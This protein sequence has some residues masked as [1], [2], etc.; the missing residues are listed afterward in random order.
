MP[1]ILKGAERVLITCVSD[2]VMAVVSP[3][4]ELK[5]DRVHI[6][7]YVR[8][9]TEGKKD[10]QAREKYYR[11]FIDEVKKQFENLHIPIEYHG[12]A[13]TYVFNE[14]MAEVYGTI[15]KET[16]LGS[17]IYVNISG[18]TSEYAA[19]AYVSAMMGKGIELF[20]T[21]M[22]PN[23]SPD[24][25]DKLIAAKTVDGQLVGSSKE[26]YQMFTLTGFNIEPPDI[27]LLMA[28]KVFSKLSKKNRT[29]STV[30]ASLI[31]H[32]VW[33]A[34]KDEE[35]PIRGTSLDDSMGIKTDKTSCR[36][37]EAVQYQRKYI[38]NWLS[39]GWVEHT[40]RRGSYEITRDG[41]IYLEIFC[42]DEVF[43]V[44]ESK[45][46]KPL[47]RGPKPDYN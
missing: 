32:G 38:D 30:I 45:L 42:P 1:E 2:E 37:T 15:L 41:K 3:A 9:A 47:R 22:K 40:D 46:S 33:Y 8:P 13:R 16:N 34:T 11:R 35:D 23:N 27:N 10:E 21:G 24:H 18:G 20:S 36:R 5:I 4:I 25:Y 43:T 39:H 7:N 26:F 12:T 17:K 44:D 29:N 14:I 19:A 28:L 31:R 6:M